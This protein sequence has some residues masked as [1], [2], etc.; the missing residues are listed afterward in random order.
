[1]SV[2]RSLEPRKLVQKRLSVRANA[3]AKPIDQFF[4]QIDVKPDF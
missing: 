2:F 1:M 3:S 4:F